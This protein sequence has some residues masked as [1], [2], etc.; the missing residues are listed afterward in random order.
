MIIAVS[1]GM[2][3][4]KNYHSRLERDLAVQIGSLQFREGSGG[5]ERSRMFSRVKTIQSGSWWFLRGFRQSSEDHG[6]LQK[7][8]GVQKG[9]WTFRGD[10]SGTKR[11]MTV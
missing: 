8:Q 10:P 4:S 11:I 6:G 3:R 1:I 5:P 2:R 9:S 7:I